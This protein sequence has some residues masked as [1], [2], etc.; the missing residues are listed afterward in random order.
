MIEKILNVR[1]FRKKETGVKKVAEKDLPKQMVV[2]ALELASSGGFQYVFVKD[3]VETRMVWTR[4]GEDIFSVW[5]SHEGN[6][7]ESKCVIKKSGVDARY[8][9][10]ISFRMVRLVGIGES[11]LFTAEHV[12]LSEVRRT[13][14]SEKRWQP[15]IRLFIESQVD[16]DATRRNFEE[17]LITERDFI[18]KGS[19]IVEW[20]NNSRRDQGRAP[21]QKLLS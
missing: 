15:I 3:N 17:Y 21:I 5:V 6:N 9:D 13:S 14:L 16:E 8:F 4:N 7:S 12:D 18:N 2:R 20:M 19:V 11:M 10:E 1:P